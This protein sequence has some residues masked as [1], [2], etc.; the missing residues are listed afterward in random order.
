MALLACRNQISGKLGTAG[1]FIFLVSLTLKN[2][3]IVYNG[4][5]VSAPRSIISSSMFIQFDSKQMA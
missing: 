3:T 2:L 4:S 1:I 5:E